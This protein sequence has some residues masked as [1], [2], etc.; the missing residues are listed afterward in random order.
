MAVSLPRRQYDKYYIIIRGL[1][2]NI[3]SNYSRMLFWC[4][5]VWPRKSTAVTTKLQSLHNNTIAINIQQKRRWTDT[6]RQIACHT[7]SIYFHVHN[8]SEPCKLN[9]RKHDIPSY[10]VTSC[11]VQQRYASLTRNKKPHL[12]ATFTGI[13]QI[14]KASVKLSMSP[15]AVTWNLYRFFHCSASAFDVCLLNYLLNYL[16]TFGFV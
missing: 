5:P 4:H 11:L 1:C 8:V 6:Y 2:S 12:T 9:Q 13:F 14:Y 15:K 7:F 16:L 3:N 10:I